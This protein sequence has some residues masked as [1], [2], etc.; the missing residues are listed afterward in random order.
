M[1][2]RSVI[3]ALLSVVLTTVNGCAPSAGA[4]APRY[5]A[6]GP[7]PTGFIVC[8]GCGCAYETRIALTPE[9]WRRVRALFQPP[10][11]DPA[12]ERGKVATAVALLERAVG[13]RTG[14]S[15]HQRRQTFNAGDATQVDC[16][17]EAID[18]SIYLALLERDGLLRHHVVGEIL[19][20]ANGLGLD[21]HNTAVLVAQE[22]A[23]RFAVDPDLVDAGVPP[24][25]LP[26]SAWLG[27]WPP[28]VPRAQGSV[29]T[30]VLIRRPPEAARL[31]GIVE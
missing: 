11:S 13:E 28:A 27:P 29:Q 2:R 15:A 23:E 25:I 14:T 19:H 1:T 8:H 10:P 5:G 4:L 18:T 26:V 31:D 16:I 17:D 7:S 3:A 21:A 30:P 9:E 12:D 24:P 20:R 22:T 6:E